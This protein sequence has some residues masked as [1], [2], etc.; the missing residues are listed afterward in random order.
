MPVPAVLIA[1]AIIMSSLSH[2]SGSWARGWA[3]PPRAGHQAGSLQVGLEQG[4]GPSWFCFGEKV[5]WSQELAGEEK[6]RG[7][8]PGGGGAAGS[9][10]VWTGPKGAESGLVTQ[11]P[12]LGLLP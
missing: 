12:P 2:F 9:L 1:G 7:R 4:R 11:E 6:E 8:Q 10:A 5:L 3:G